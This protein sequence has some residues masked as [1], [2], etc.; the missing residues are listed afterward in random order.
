MITIKLHKRCGRSICKFFRE[1]RDA[2]G[3]LLIPADTASFLGYS[4][5]YF[6]LYNKLPPNVVVSNDNYLLMI[7]QLSQGLEATAQ[8]CSTGYLWEGFTGKTGGSM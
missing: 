8:A 3:Y 6:L 2:P 7:L 1:R 4:F 5:S